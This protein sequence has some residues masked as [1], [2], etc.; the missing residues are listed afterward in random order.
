MASS[1]STYS[2]SHHQFENRFDRLTSASLSSNR[3]SAA[4]TSTDYVS[5]GAKLT[6]N[7]P[8]EAELESESSSS[9]YSSGNHVELGTPGSD[10]SLDS[11]ASAPSPGSHH[12]PEE[13]IPVKEVAWE[14][15]AH[16]RIERMIEREARN[17]LKDPAH[18]ELDLELKY[19]VVQ[20]I[21]K[22]DLCV[23]GFPTIP[24][25]TRYRA[26]ALFSR[27]WAICPSLAEDG[28][29]RDEVLEAAWH[30]GVACLILACKADIDSHQPL[31][32]LTLNS[33]VRRVNAS[34]RILI[35]VT[36]L[37][38][39]ERDVLFL[40][41]YDITAPTPTDFLTELSMASPQLAKLVKA[42]PEDWEL[43]GSAFNIIL[44]RAVQDHNYTHFPSTV[45]TAAALFM[46][47]EGCLFDHPLEQNLV[48][49]RQWSRDPDGTWTESLRPN[50]PKTVRVCVVSEFMGN[51][52]VEIVQEE[53][54]AS[55]CQIL[56]LNEVEQ[57]QSWCES[58]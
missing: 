8:S 23:N 43:I 54:K 39:V 2:A 7:D 18:C 28:V 17:S 11:E 31:F 41:S 1:N 6:E 21:L 38:T 51:V 49:G 47:L 52:M 27:F 3:I 15:R 57:C 56:G 16:D 50:L 12:S 48:Q 42:C 46:S 34:S 58:L 25:P 10:F 37:E 5:S 13:I 26:I 44:E 29:P 4:E 20:W 40:L 19:D 53:I 14:D 55:V 9:E 36:S 45:I 33:W 32:C 24:F 35:D 30:I 22:F